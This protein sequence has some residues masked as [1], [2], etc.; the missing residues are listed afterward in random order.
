MQEK[1]EN[2]FICPLGQDSQKDLGITIGQINCDSKTLSSLT[3]QKFVAILEKSL[4]NE[5][6]RSEPGETNDLELMLKE[7]ASLEE[8]SRRLDEEGKRLE[9][10]VR[11]HIEELAQ[12]TKKRNCE[13]QK[14]NMDL[15]ARVDMLETQLRE[16][17][18][19]ETASGESIAEKIDY[20]PYPSSSEASQDE[21]LDYDQNAIA[22]EIIEEIK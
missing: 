21:L 18:I 22:V 17:S 7:K 14:A 16:L 5:D 4:E 1:S 12:E 13:K 9:V 6:K 20:D 2:V 11:I 8:E 15:R 19:L 10:L 3:Q